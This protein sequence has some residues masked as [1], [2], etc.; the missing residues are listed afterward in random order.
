LPGPI[1][2]PL[3]GNLHL[4]S[5]DVHLCFTR[6][7]SL[8]G[9]VYS[10]KLGAMEVV[11]FSD[12]K[13]IVEA[14]SQKGKYTRDRI[15]NLKTRN[16][17]SGNF[18]GPVRMIG[19]FLGNG[20]LWRKN[21]KLTAKLFH[22]TNL[23]E[24][25]GHF[26]Y[27]V[28]R[29]LEHLREKA[30]AKEPIDVLHFITTTNCNLIMAALIGAKGSFRE[31]LPVQSHIKKV[32]DAM[33]VMATLELFFPWTNIFTSKQRRNLV[34][35]MQVVRTPFQTRLDAH[36]SQPE[37][38]R[39]K[40]I[41]SF[42]LENEEVLEGDQN[43]V[44]ILD[45]LLVAATDTMS[46]TVAWAIALLI[47]HPNILA[48]LQQELDLN[49]KSSTPQLEDLE[50]LPLLSAVIN[51]TLRMYPTAPLADLH[52]VS[53]SFTV[54]SYIIPKNVAIIPN[55]WGVHR[56]PN[57]WPNPTVWDPYRF[58]NNT[59]L[60]GSPQFIP[61]GAGPRMCLGK[62]LALV[63]T[64]LILGVLIQ[65]FDFKS[66]QGNQIPLVADMGITLSPKQYKVLVTRRS[67]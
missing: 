4:F 29:M 5:K 44:S 46:S 66:T 25:Q 30:D 40:D 41:F 45:N 57:F 24:Y 14:L 52:Y 11:V 31:E 21:R 26:Q 48:S 51:E 37:K 63:Q 17:L 58:V 27:L 22:K 49:L 3:I 32:I 7:A 9:A 65:N 55:I 38:H 16:I 62:N 33:G 50:K 47:N 35:M 10:V 18:S 28:P 23:K 56:N 43:I 15:V 36:H 20:D 60:E 61:F 59:S 8:Y 6:L 19:G 12:P 54:G 1:R 67:L 2:L 39:S 42:L 13:I 34:N 64:K 53:E